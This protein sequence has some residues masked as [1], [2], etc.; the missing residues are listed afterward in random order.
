MPQRAVQPS[1][2]SP[3]WWVLSRFHCLLN[4]LASRNPGSSTQPQQEGQP[5][6]RCQLT[7]QRRSQ[8]SAILHTMP[9]EVGSRSMWGRE[10]KTG[11]LEAA[12]ASWAAA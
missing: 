5:G 12:P 7:L 1:W 6:Y 10:L 2:A 3:P 9:R 8:Q 4:S 11:A